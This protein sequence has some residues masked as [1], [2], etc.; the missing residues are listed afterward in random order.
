ML[1]A[2]RQRRDRYQHNAAGAKEFVSAGE[3]PRE[4]QIADSELAAWTSIMSMILN[5]DEAITK[6]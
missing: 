4:A 3:S 5:L 6:G 2:L 1:N